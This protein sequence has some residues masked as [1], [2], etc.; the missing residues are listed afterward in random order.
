[1]IIMIG[2]PWDMIDFYNFTLHHH[3]TSFEL[4]PKIDGPLANPAFVRICGIP[5][6]CFWHQLDI[7]CLPLKWL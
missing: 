6:T 4:T 1:M 7:L 3:Q 2:S 5:A